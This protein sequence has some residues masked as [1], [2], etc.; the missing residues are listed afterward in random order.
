MKKQDEF[1]FSAP[2]QLVALGANLSSTGAGLEATLQTAVR[3]I[4][5]T[6][7]AIRAVSRFY[8]TPC[9]PAG[10]G[11]DY[12]NAALAIQ[13][14]LTPQE[15]LLKL[16]AIEADFGRER[17]QRWGQRTLDLDLIADGDF[18]C[19]SLGVFQDWFGLDPALQAQTA[20]DELVLPH[21]RLQ[22]RGFVLVPLN[23][24]A[25]NWRHP[26]LGKTIA[27]LLGERPLSEIARIQPL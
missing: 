9:F 1:P 26:V 16:H 22:D 18:V 5:Q 20:P 8:Q 6:G 10:A 15:I 24:I 17:V 7:L 23:D 25:P 12:L 19:P 11:P 4:A 27:D 21:P 2:L 14:P 13:T 3:A